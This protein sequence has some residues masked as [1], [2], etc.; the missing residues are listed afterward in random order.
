M[1]QGVLGYKYELEKNETGYTGLA[2]LPLYL[3]LAT[4]TGLSRAMDECIGVRGGRQGWKDGQVGMAL[5]LLNL[6]GGDKVEDIQKLEGDEGFKQI[7]E[8][9]EL[10]EMSRRERREQQRRWR[11]EKRRAVPSPSAIFRYLSRFHDAEQEKR[12]V[13][14]KAFIPQPNAALRGLVQVN[15]KLV[16]SVYRQQGGEVA[17]LDQDATLVETDKKGALYCYEH[18]KAYQPFNTYWAE[19]GLVLHTEF[20]DG[21]VPAGYEQ[22]RVLQESL[23][24]LPEGVKKVRLRSDTAAY[25]HEVLKYC[26]E[27]KHPRLGVIEFAISADVTPEFRRA[28]AEVAEEEWQPI[29]RDVKGEKVKTGREWAEVCFVPNWA[30]RSKKG[31]SY[32]YLATREVMEN[33]LPGLEPPSS[34]PFQTLE[35]KRQRYKVFGTVTNL[36]WAGEE[37]IEWQHQR[38]GKSEEVHKVMKEDLAGASLPSGDFGENAAWWWFMVLALNLNEALK[39]HVLKGEWSQRRMKALRFGVIQLVGRVVEKARQLRIR[40]GKAGI[41]YELILRARERMLGWKAAA[42]G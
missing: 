19:Q 28:V 30:G 21:N 20:R 7:L 1:A 12:R 38:C 22:V 33:F 23:E 35:M 16:E 18:Y 13:E 36:D 3:E 40:L 24:L 41:G 17:T 15:R 14:G 8:R 34:L 4:L 26:A 9:V 29:W 39:R 32:R 31:P 10:N 25:Q 5:I 2:G 27:G 11:K 42:A 6:A 37:V